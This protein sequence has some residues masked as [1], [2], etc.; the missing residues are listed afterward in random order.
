MMLERTREK[1]KPEA[2]FALRSTLETWRAFLN[3]G[4]PPFGFTFLT[5]ARKPED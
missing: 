5:L 4:D 2:N 1:V 3:K